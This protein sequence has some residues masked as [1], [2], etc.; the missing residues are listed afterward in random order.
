[1]L[2][3]SSGGEKPCW[4]GTSSTRFLVFLGSSGHEF[5]RAWHPAR[6]MGVSGRVVVVTDATSPVGEAIATHALNEGAY[7]IANQ[8]QD[9]SSRAGATHVI[10]GA[11][12][13]YGR[14]DVLVNSRQVARDGSVADLSEAEWDEVIVGNL[15]AAYL[16]T[17]LTSQAMRR[18][19]LGCIVNVAAK[20]GLLGA[21]GQANFVA[22]QSGIAAFTR[23]IARDLANLG[24]TVNLVVT[25]RQTGVEEVSTAAVLT[26]YLAGDAGARAHGM[27]FLI[28]GRT[29]S[30]LSHPTPEASLFSGE[31]WESSNLMR[32]M[33][34]LL[35]KT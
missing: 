34:G 33:P 13:A 12:E 23:V 19:R 6:M 30:V 11:L 26:S 32:L 29:I 1:M 24:I 8:D 22:A 31:L 10:G 4:L 2:V 17:H 20:E 27:H 9:V 25:P 7:V 3:N 21:V 28:D 5:G 15:R 18:S 35:E 16:C 14:I